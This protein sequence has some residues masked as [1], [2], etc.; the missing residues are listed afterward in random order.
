MTRT[1]TSPRT[2]LRG[3]EMLSPRIP[4][5]ANRYKTSSA[6][7]L[8]CGTHNI[9][10]S[11]EI[12][13]LL[14]AFYGKTGIE[15]GRKTLAMH[16]DKFRMQLGSTT[17][18]IE[19][20]VSKLGEVYQTLDAQ[21]NLSR[22]PVQDSQQNATDNISASEGAS[23]SAEQAAMQLHF[24]MLFFV[25]ISLKISEQSLKDDLRLHQDALDELQETL[26]LLESHETRTADA[27]K[28]VQNWVE[29][30]SG[31]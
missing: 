11:V 10:P 6:S 21:P 27:L 31:T 22:E 19:L 16:V 2:T 3:P 13:T 30:L 23:D 4:Y 12:Y 24:A 14:V 1:V 8:E 18:A 29:P 17:H 15:I 5:L 20:V 28:H 7:A 25:F 26:V 9:C